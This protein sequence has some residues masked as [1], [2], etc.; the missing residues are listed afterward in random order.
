M[1]TNDPHITWLFRPKKP[2]LLFPVSKVIRCDHATSCVRSCRHGVTKSEEDSFN[3]ICSLT[4]K[5]LLVVY[6]TQ[7]YNPLGIWWSE[8]GS[9]SHSRMGNARRPQSAW[10]TI[11]Y[12]NTWYIK[13][14]N[15]IDRMKIPTE[16]FP[17]L[18]FSV[19]YRKR[20]KG[21]IWTVCLYLYN[22]PSKFEVGYFYMNDSTRN[23]LRK[24]WWMM[25]ICDRDIL[26]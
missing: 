26:G 13:R 5:L 22:F 4:N 12:L 16:M 1:I 19:G 8:C 9:R 2:F 18:L 6:H 10:H 14:D 20:N 3:F 23:E 25:S 11:L 17:V 21:Q 15:I 24:Q 7:Y